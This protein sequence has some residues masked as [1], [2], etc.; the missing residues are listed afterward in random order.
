VVFYR[1]KS[2]KR[3]ST[4]LFSPSSD[5]VLAANKFGDILV[6][7]VGK[8]GDQPSESPMNVFLGHFCSTI[9]S[10]AMS[11]DDSLIASSDRD[12]RIRITSFPQN[13]MDGAHEIVSFCLGHEN[14]VSVCSFISDG[15]Q[16]YLLTGGGD[17][18]LKLWDPLQGKELDSVGVSMPPLA[19]VP[20]IERNA[21]ITTLDG[22]CDVL[23]ASASDGKIRIDT[24]KL[25]LPVISD[26]SLAHDG[27]LWFAGG[28]VGSTTGLR[29]AAFELVQNSLQH[30][31]LSDILKDLES[32]D[33]DDQ[34]LHKTHLPDFLDKCKPHH[35]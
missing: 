8:I 1:S 5:H 28:P 3:L 32:C 29:L 18:T 17:N 22:S 14:F 24:H 6:A 19:M 23:I 2:P 20:N 12:G 27:K 10:V 9:T 15:K 26:V 7:P 13:P 35:H 21:V 34:P 16:E 4:V 31:E 33:A 30:V 25:N 11:R